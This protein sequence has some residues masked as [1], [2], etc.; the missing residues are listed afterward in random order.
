MKRELSYLE[1][2]TAID[3]IEKFFERQ[4]ESRLSL[5]KVQSPLLIKR[6][7]EL[8]DTLI[9]ME[10]VVSFTK[11][12]EN[13]E[14]VHSL[15]KWKRN[16]LGQYE[17]PMHT[18]LYTD[19]RSIRGDEKVDEMHSLF[20]EQWDFEKV[21][22]KED[23]TVEYLK[24]TVRS[25]YKA[26]RQT[27]IFVKQK[28]HFIT[29]YL[30]KTITFVTR[31]ELEDLYPD[32][33]PREREDLITREKRSVFIIGTSHDL[34]EPGYDDWSLN[35]D[36]FIYNKM[37]DK[38]VEIASMGISV[39]E[40]ALIYQFEKADCLDKLNLPYYQKIKKCM[41]PYTI[42]GSIDKSIIFMLLLEKSH[43]AEVQAS[44]WDEK[45]LELLQGKMVLK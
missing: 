17:F 8:Q 43:I 42:G 14:I 13:F 7:D 35:G 24:E 33:T 20:V 29:T 5:R 38:A 32:R 37:I 39:D 26:I 21:I 9:G 44:S 10:K 41:L 19:R 11:G 18:G 36:M 30:P 15:K 4:L 34:R 1:T 31:Q 6:G 28:Y 2:V 40:K 23:R 27:S 45:T 16:I 25:V 12:D 3:E 22:C